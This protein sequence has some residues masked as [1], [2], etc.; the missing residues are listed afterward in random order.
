MKLKLFCHINIQFSFQFVE[1]SKT[2]MHTIIRHAQHRLLDSKRAGD[3]KTQ[4][5]SAASGTM[6][7]YTRH[8]RRHT[9]PD[10]DVACIKC[11]A[12]AESHP[13]S[14]T[15]TPT[16]QR[17]STA[18]PPHAATTTRILCTVFMPTPWNGCPDIFMH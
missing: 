1:R 8:T 6:R 4:A 12:F 10:A 7:R 11:D 5:L 13:H 18:T 15:N 3:N 14:H 16:T 17:Y 9:H 2:L